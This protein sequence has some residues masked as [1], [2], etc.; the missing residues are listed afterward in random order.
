LIRGA[1]DASWECVGKNALLSVVS[2]ISA[3]L[4]CLL[5][6]L[7]ASP[8]CCC[9]AEAAEEREAPC[10]CGDPAGE[11]EKEPCHGCLCASDDPREIPDPAVVPPQGL[12]ISL[13]APP[14]SVADLPR[15][16]SMDLARPRWT[17]ASPWHAP[18][19]ERRA[20]LVS[21]LL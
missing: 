7:V 2:R 5:A 21:R 6:L 4:A 12:G 11:N 20:R 10:C 16:R 15:I 17:P 19:A 14:A 18:P 3:I 8:L 13:E 1:G 9:A